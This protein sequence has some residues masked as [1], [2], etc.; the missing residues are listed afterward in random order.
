MPFA[1]YIWCFCAQ[2]SFDLVN[3]T[4]DLLTLEVSDELSFIHPTHIPLL[5]SYDYRFLSYGWLNLI[6]LTSHGASLRNFVCNVYNVMIAVSYDHVS[7][8]I[9]PGVGKNYPHFWKPRPKFVY[10]LCYFQGA[11]RRR[12]SHAISPGIIYSLYNFYGA[13]MTIKVIY[14]WASPC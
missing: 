3:L 10:L 5:V 7:R 8:D 1:A 12:L 9:S 11:I 6:I 13:T 4:F 14:I 2:F